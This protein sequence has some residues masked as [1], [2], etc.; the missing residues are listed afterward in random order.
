MLELAHLLLS[1]GWQIVEWAWSG[2]H[3]AS[4]LARK[5]GQQRRAPDGVK[6]P[7]RQTLEP[8]PTRDA[9]Y[10][11]NYVI[12]IPSGGSASDGEYV[13]SSC[14]KHMREGTDVVSVWCK[15]R[16]MQHLAKL[17]AGNH[18]SPK[19]QAAFNAKRRQPRSKGWTPFT[20]SM[21]SNDANVTCS[22]SA[23]GLTT[24]FQV[25]D[26]VTIHCTCLAPGQ[27]I[28]QGVN[29]MVLREQVGINAALLKGTLLNCS[30]LAGAPDVEA[31]IRGGELRAADPHALRPRP[32]A[33]AR[34]AADHSRSPSFGHARRRVAPVRRLHPGA[35]AAAQ[36]RRAD[37]PR[38]G[39]R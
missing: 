7:P 23:D 5:I 19:L 27:T 25:G 12:S 16:G 36:G 9:A 13:G 39:R 31:C 17:L 38:R 3:G 20:A 15:G 6:L 8:R 14:T 11:L 21:L 32:L 4:V 30:V 1:R 35:A 29:D 26:Y 37:G 22:V 28:S 34:L 24:T 18:P 33:P 2:T 10:V